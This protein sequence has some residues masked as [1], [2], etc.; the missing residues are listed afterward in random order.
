MK[1]KSFEALVI[2][3]I[4][5][6][7]ITIIF[8]HSKI[9]MKIYHL[10]LFDFRNFFFEFDEINSLIVHVHLMNAFTNKILFRNEFNRL[11]KVSRNYRLR[12][13]IEFK[14]INVYHINNENDFKNRN[15]AARRL[16]S[17]YQKN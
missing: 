10:I 17:K 14:Y 9:L 2:K 16:R 5:L 15:L 8:F 12:K 4:H 11:I 1:I 13:F 7:K 3:S 6:R